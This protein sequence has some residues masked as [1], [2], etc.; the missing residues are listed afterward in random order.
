[1]IKKFYGNIKTQNEVAVE[2][3]LNQVD[4]IGVN[5]VSIYGAGELFE[6]LLPYLKDRKITMKYVIDTRA[7]I[8][9][10]YFLGF[11]VLPLE[12][13]TLLKMI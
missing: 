7:K 11:E 10:F 2:N 8:K 4:K 1:M 6:I 3:I 5:E 12:K 13:L 9:P